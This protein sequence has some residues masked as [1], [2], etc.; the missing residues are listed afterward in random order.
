MFH[1][2]RPFS[3]TYSRENPHVVQ[4]KL[5]FQKW[6]FLKTDK[7]LSDVRLLINNSHDL[8]GRLKENFVS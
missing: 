3:L 8:G 7:V 2:L 5:V 6:N 1:A 4:G